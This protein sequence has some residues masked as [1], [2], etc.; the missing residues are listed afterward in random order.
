[1]YYPS[2]L[3]PATIFPDPNRPDFQPENRCWQGIPSLE[4]TPRGRLF[5]TFYSGGQTEGNGNY[6]VLTASDDDG[7]SWTDPLL[8]VQHADPG[9]RVFDPNVWI[10]PL[11]RLWLTWAQSHDYFDGR[12]GVWAAICADPDAVR[13]VFTAPRRIANGVM[14]GKPTVIRDGTWLFPCAVWV[15]HGTPPAE[16]H[17][18]VA[19]ER[20]SNVYAS[21]DQGNTIVW[22]GGSDVPNRHFDE[23]MVVERRDGSLWMLVRRFDGIGQGFSYDGGYTWWQ[24]G[25]AG[26]TGPDS[27]FFIRRLQS[28]NLLLVNH[29][30]FRGRNNLMA[31][32]SFDDGRTWTG[33]LM[34]DEREQVSYPDGKQDQEGVI[35]ITYD[36]ERY[37][38]REILL[39]RFTEQDVLA[40]KCVSK[41]ARLRCPVS[42]ATGSADAV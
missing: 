34:L 24:E 41:T 26:I 12:D 28:G 11:G 21:S 25:H 42:R 36:H 9:M 19:H 16:Q 29:V 13:P 35:Y 5:V 4:K 2:E 15:C 6:I 22:R 30:D 10:D 7:H 20:L 14:M 17:T 3:M 31:Q 38:D 33:G 40:G 27:R 32:L 1:M 23:H 39:A 37:R 18:E 8:T